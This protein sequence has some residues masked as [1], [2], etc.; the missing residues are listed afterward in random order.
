MNMLANILT[1]VTKCN[2]IFCSIANLF[3]VPFL[4]AYNLKRGKES[5]QL[6]KLEKKPAIVLLGI[7]WLRCKYR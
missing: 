6:V 2:M 1:Y 4:K 7:R 3:P 5:Y